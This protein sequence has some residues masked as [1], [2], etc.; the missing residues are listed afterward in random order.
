MDEGF[1]TFDHTGD[2]GLEIWAGT[3]AR[4]Y[5]LAAE[6]LL[7]QMIEA[8]NA[9]A[10]V[11]VEL[12]LEGEDASDLLVHW[13]NAEASATS[14]TAASGEGDRLLLARSRSL[15]RVLRAVYCF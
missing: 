15:R 2:L 1:R 13:L 3:P 5:S 10:E 12:E 4:L 11:S 6:A 7:A 14:T 8:P 9:A